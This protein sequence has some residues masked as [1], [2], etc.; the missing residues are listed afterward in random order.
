M[1]VQAHI[2]LAGTVTTVDPRT[3][4]ADVPDTHLASLPS[5]LTIGSDTAT[6]AL[7]LILEGTAANT[8]EI[9]VFALDDRASLTGGTNRVGAQTQDAVDREWHLVDT[10]TV[11]VGT[12]AQTSAGVT[13][14]P[15]GAFYFRVTT[16]PAADAVLGVVCV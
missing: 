8:A 5:E 6:S 12:V 15:G 4:P 13:F 16:A 7:L 14:P 3:A 1:I 10:I 9:E 11:T 2:D